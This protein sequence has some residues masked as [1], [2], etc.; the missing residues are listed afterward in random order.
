MYLCFTFLSYYYIIS[1]G[2]D[3]L[4]ANNVKSYLNVL[5]KSIVLTVKNLLLYFL[6]SLYVLIFYVGIMLFLEKKYIICIPIFI[7]FLCCISSTFA[8]IEK[9]VKTGSFSIKDFLHS[10]TKYFL[11]ANILIGFWILIFILTNQFVVT[12][13]SAIIKGPILLYLIKV[14]LII[15]IFFTFNSFL[16]YIYLSEENIE[17]I[18]ISS[19][20]FIEKNWL[21]WSIINII[22]LFLL[23]LYDYRLSI[24]PTLGYLSKE[25]ILF[26]FNDLA[27]YARTL[28]LTIALIFRGLLF[29]ELNKK[30][31]N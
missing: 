11:R 30:V 12:P 14:P 2:G 1:Y 13:I 31:A 16:E 26:K 22:T 19:I 15:L 8:L 5:A 10:F 27:F 24:I 17:S 9:V 25:E 6:I 21:V 3:T 4:T 20:K 18:F 29:V 23:N 7:V 28:V